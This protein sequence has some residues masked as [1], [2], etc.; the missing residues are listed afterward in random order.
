MDTIAKIMGIAFMGAVMCVVLKEKV[1]QF[2]MVVSL[3]TGIVI[4]SLIAS[5]LRDVIRQINLIFS[6]VQLEGD[7]FSLV[8]KICGIGIVSEY[9][10]SLISDVGESAIAKKAELAAKVV[11]FVMI[12]P[13]VGKVVDTV[14]SLF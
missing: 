9:F 3:L 14:W 2:S 5:Q 7:L 10:C 13:L 8:L 11:I 4:L 6:R 12:L 1:P